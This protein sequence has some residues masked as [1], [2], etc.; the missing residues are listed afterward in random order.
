MDRQTKINDFTSALEAISTSINHIAYDISS[1]LIDDL[2]IS[3]LDYI[4]NYPT[5]ICTK[6]EIKDVINK[7]YNKK[8]LNLKRSIA[9]NIETVKYSL[10]DSNC[11]I[12]LAIKSEIEKYKMIFTSISA[13][14]NINYLGLV[15]ECTQNVMSLLIR[16]NTS[17]SF[18]KHIKEIEQ[19][20]FNLI[21]DSFLK[22]MLQMGDKL[23]DD[24]ILSI[25]SDFNLGKVKIKAEEF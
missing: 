10:E 9:N 8:H 11:D 16:K 19:Y 5:I 13:G 2:V 1:P 7:A 20:I 4:R 3:I 21:N 24:G 23:L 14:T 17:I 18:A 12:D 15:D 6:D 22:V 25:E